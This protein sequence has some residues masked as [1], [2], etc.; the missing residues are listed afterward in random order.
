[1]KQML[2]LLLLSAMLLSETRLFG[3]APT[4]CQKIVNA[5]VDAVN[6]RSAAHLWE[7]LSEDFVCANQKGAVAVRVLEMIVAQL[8]DEVTG[9]TLSS[10]EY[11]DGV[12]TQVYDFD[13]KMRG[14]KSVTFVFDAD[15]K[16]KQLELV[17]AKVKTVNTRTEFELP[18]Q[19]IITIPFEIC[20]NL[21]IVKA[22]INGIMRD[23]ILDS[24]APT[25]MLNSA[26]F[27]GNDEKRS[28]STVQ[29]INSSVGGADITRIESFDF[30]GITARDRDFL[31]SDLSH[32]VAGREIYGLIGAQVIKDF[33]WLFDYKAGTL[34]LIRPDRTADHIVENG[35]RA[36][37][38]P[39]VMAS[40]TSHIPC[41]KASADGLDLLL[42]IDC[43]ATAN[44]LDDSLWDRLKKS[45]K[46]RSSATLKGASD[47]ATTVR[48]ATL[49]SLTIGD[50]TFK[51]L[52]TAFSDIDALQRNWQ[53]EVAG[54]AG[55]EILSR[56][57]CIVSIHS[58]K[59]MFLE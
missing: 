55:Y 30:G 25:L 40:E 23:F 32:L 9:F 33:D 48:E 51:E 56:Q 20:D 26:W 13:Y 19:Q 14:H 15:N 49:K 41:L 37:S 18:Q 59:I 2:V 7:Y 4:E 21:L 52:R 6:S 53:Q 27:K 45:L 54:L 11:G 42:G 1:M 8:A 22:E 35:L 58:K 12:L 16:L 29:G 38:A 57:P 39:L 34:T 36:H 46:K 5:T 43:G 50:V 3:Q 10:E 47:T 24:G 28:I 31:M 17:S 44:L